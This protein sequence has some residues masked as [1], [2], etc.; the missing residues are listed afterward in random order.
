LGRVLY[1]VGCG[2]DFI[3][4]DT[5]RS[6]VNV[7]QKLGIEVLISRDQIC[8]S[9][10]IFL[11][12]AADMALPNIHK[13]IKILDQS[14]VDAIVTDCATCGAA[15]KKGIPQLLDDMGLDS[16]KAYRIA[17][18]VV[19]VSQLVVQHLEMLEIRRLQNA[20][21]VTYHDPCHLGRGMG[22]I[23]EP[24][25]IL[26]AIGNL[27]LVEME[28]SNECCGG[29]GSYQFEKK[30]I[31]GGITAR[32]AENILRTGA[33]LVATGCPGCRLTIGATLP[34]TGIETI[35]TLQLLEQALK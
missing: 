24:R 19:D 13:N 8:C 26:Q 31:S 5:G 25:R 17:E 18:K 12:G 2:T 3:F 15:L 9:A 28:G 1:F 34:D 11:S 30:R 6:V 35:H 16:E 10:P 23:A 32:K 14:D 20:A 33:H 21:I 7:L 29:G 4:P 27:D 22:I